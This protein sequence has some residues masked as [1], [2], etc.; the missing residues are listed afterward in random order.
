MVYH[1]PEKICPL[2]L[3][4][5]NF[6]FLKDYIN[7][8]GNF[9]LYECGNCGGQFWLPFVNPGAK[10]YEEKDMYNIK[11][12][13]KLRQIHSYHKKFFSIYR[14]K[15]SG[16]NLLDIGCGTG[17]FI[18]SAKKYGAI[19]YGV[20]I[21]SQAIEIAKKF[22]N[23]ENIY[24]SPIE[25]FFDNHKLPQLDVVTAFEVFEHVAAPYIILKE[26]RKLLRPGAKLILSI[27]T[28]KR[29][30][31]NIAGWDYPFHHL[32]RWD[33][34]SIIFIL[35]AFGYKDVK[36]EHINRFHQLYELF[37]EIIAKKLKFNKAHGMKK[38]A[39]NKV[40]NGIKPFKKKIITIVYKI[41]RYIGVI[42]IPYFFTIICYPL[43][44]IFFPQSGIMYIEA[45]N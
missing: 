33:K 7:N 43:L 35:T 2:C 31:V 13:N 15:I 30:F 14:N 6:L 45:K 8:N 18:D 40:K 16:L 34:N 9:S 21:D 38:I 32:S 3:K 17:E 11:D 22:Y 41:A 1:K 19:V 44:R 29:P 4:N 23:L 20:D 28:R 39:N 27:P 42:L 12:E 10:W 36:V 37:L 5:S 24:N 26:A 25:K